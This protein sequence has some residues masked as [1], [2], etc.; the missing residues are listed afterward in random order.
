MKELRSEPMLY[1]GIITMIIA[2][3]F[4]V[5]ALFFYLIPDSVTH[6]EASRVN[7]YLNADNINGADDTAS[8][9]KQTYY[10]KDPASLESLMQLS[11]EKNDLRGIKYYFALWSEIAA[12]PEKAEKMQAVIDRM[13]LQEDFRTVTAL[14]N[15]GNTEEALEYLS[16]LH[17]KYPSREDITDLLRRL[18]IETAEK[19]WS[20]QDHGSALTLLFEVENMMSGDEIIRNE[21]LKIA[22]SAVTEY[23]A[24]Q[25]YTDAFDV[26][27]KCSRLFGTDVLNERRADIARIK[28]D[29]RLLQAYMAGL[30]KA[31]KDKDDQ[32]IKEILDDKEFRKAVNNIPECVYENALLDSKL[33]GTGMALYNFNGSPFVYYGS[34]ADGQRNGEAEW[35]FID[36]NDELCIYR[37]N[38]ENDLPEGNVECFRKDTLSVYDNKGRKIESFEVTVSEN[39]AVKGGIADGKCTASVS[40]NKSFFVCEKNYK[41]GYL[42]PVD[43][44][45]LPEGLDKYMDHPMPLAGWT[46]A[47]LYDSYWKKNYK[48]TIW[49][50]APKEQRCIEGIYPENSNAKLIE[51]RLEIL[52]ENKAEYY[53]D[54]NGFYVTANPKK[55]PLPRA[56][57]A[58]NAS[59]SYL[60]DVLHPLDRSVYP[61]AAL[62]LD[63]VGWDLKAA[64]YWSVNT[65][66]YYGHGKPDMPENGSPGTQWFADFGFEK[67][68][69][70]CFV[71]AA[72][73]CEMAR[74]LGYPCRQMYGQVPAA[75]GG[76]TPHS[77]TEIDINGS[78]YVFD[79]EFHHAT[80]KNGF[81]INYGTPGTW[82]YTAYT[83]MND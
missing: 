43:E 71:F 4:F 34:Y 7:E 21:L 38:F 25:R 26:V 46:E 77:W 44:N 52:S 15:D 31:L 11:Y 82:R 56:A 19:R 81:M 35:L 53:S 64:Y 32:K 62:A 63:S 45:D 76:L 13:E 30:I 67:H 65:L 68:K 73:F 39:F 23:A 80:G 72:T 78:T 28:E 55:R 16:R 66:S 10:S 50:C 42:E 49:Y 83:P 1:T 79:P 51:G 61:A 40:G 60:P 27:Y 29:D 57:A 58:Q 12:D 48:T 74:L 69:G 22:D 3:I 37:L 6:R 54:D 41:D 36:G 17:E 47:E 9:L 2:V 75:R 59:P 8:V 70:N 14:I 24:T 33:S 18:A 20:G 5:F